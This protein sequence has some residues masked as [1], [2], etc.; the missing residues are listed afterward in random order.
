M[1]RRAFSGVLTV[2]LFVSLFCVTVG[3]EEETQGFAEEVPDSFTDFLDAL[4]DDLLK[5][6]PNGIFSTNTEEVGE[7]A[8]EISSFSYLL[9]TVLSMLGL[10]IGDFVRL[11]ATVAGLLVLSAIAKALQ[12]SFRD[13]HIGRAFSFC[14]TLV[15]CASLLGAGYTSISNVR[16]YFSALR[17]AT[18]ASVPLLASLYA[19]GGNVTGAVASSSGLSLFLVILEEVVGATVIPFCGICLSLAV[20]GVLDPSLR[21]QTFLS[22]I[23][24]NYTT[25]LTFLMMLLLAMLG[26]QTTLGARRDTLAMKSVK[27]AAGNM[28]PVVGGSISE[29][30]RTVSAGVGYL[31]GGVGVCGIILLLLLLLPT[32]IEL[33]LARLTWELAASLADLLGCDSEKKLLEEFAS[34]GGYLIAAVAICASVPI[35]SYSL[36]LHCASAIA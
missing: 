13:E 16:D 1:M 18:A 24:K 14:T 32:L 33:F 21:I 4:P 28:I 6:L 36:L 25:V 17:G 30:L 20:A 23:K 19:M 3:A 11:F 15:I 35:L 10:R 5:R 27:F 7:V 12:G 22:T 8:E 2:L 34:L 29:L 31:R 26:A 9:E